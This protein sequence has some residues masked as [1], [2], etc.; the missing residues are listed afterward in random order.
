VN[1]PHP[2]APTEPLPAEAHLSLPA[3]RPTRARYV[4]LAFLCAL[5]FILYL[6]R[7]C[8]GQ[9]EE[10]IRREFSTGTFEFTKTHMTWVMIAFL[11]SYGLFEAPAGRWGDRY[12]TRG[13]LM[14]IVTAWSAFTALTGATF[15]L[16]SLIAV[17]FLFGAGEAGAF[18]NT[19]RVLTRWFPDGERGRVQG[20]LLG[21]SLL[22]GAAAPP[23]AGA[24]IAA[25][26]WRWSFAIF[27]AVGVVWAVLFYLWFRD[28]P[29]EH[30][31]AN[32]EERE[33][34]ARGRR[35]ARADRAHEPIPWRYVLRSP[36]VWLLTLI[37]NCGAFGQYIFIGWFPTYLKEGRGV[38][39]PL[40]LDWFGGITL[41]GEVR[42]GLL[43]GMVLSGGVVGCLLGG[44]Y[45][46][47]VVRSGVD[48][49]WARR[50]YGFAVMTLAS[51][52]AFA[53]TQVDSPVLAALVI[54][55]ACLGVQMQ[56]ATW[57]AVTQEISGRHVGSLFGLM[58]GA[59]VI[60]AASS[61]FFFGWFPTYREA[62]GFAGRA[63]WDPAF[64]VDAGVLFCGALLWLFIDPTRSA[65]GPDE[66][67]TAAAPSEAAS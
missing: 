1:R 31:A 16:W 64:W 61:I 25:I 62:L 29:A 19:A 21:C 43:A 58:N 66:P 24:L 53:S 42:S 22:G 28:D 13:V 20:L 4:V 38:R 39:A 5:A 51:A 35:L 8:L 7:V 23:V 52:A 11:V 41:A 59:A 6:D 65:V 47:W 3:A 14:K 27:G 26:G 40:R 49:R 33:L 37:Q 12:G 55:G 44:L 32:H 57:W 63:R 9:A 18:P 50:L 36:E 54:A 67:H 56:Q 10:S 46:E 15:G 17:R 30:P 34:I 2:D 60:G 48:R 45:A